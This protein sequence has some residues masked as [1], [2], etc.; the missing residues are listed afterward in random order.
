MRLICGCLIAI[1]AVPAAGQDRRLP[2]Y[3]TFIAEA[4]K[5]L[6]ADDVR[7]AE[8][9]LHNKMWRRS[10]DIILAPSTEACV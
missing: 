7:R 2:D 4:R 9:V 6:E 10:H 3:A 5:R 8:G 1:L